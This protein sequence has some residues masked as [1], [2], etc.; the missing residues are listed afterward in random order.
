M[1][2]LT[3]ALSTSVLAASGAPQLVCY[4]VSDPDRNIHLIY[5]AHELNLNLYKRKSS[6][7]LLPDCSTESAP[8]LD[9]CRVCV[10]EEQVTA[11]CYLSDPSADL[12]FEAK[13]E[14][15]S[16]TRI[17][18]VSSTVMA[19]TAP[20]TRSAA[21][22][23]P[24]GGS[25]ASIVYG[26]CGGLCFLVLAALAYCQRKKIKSWMPC[27]SFYR[28]VLKDEEKETEMTTKP[29]AANAKGPTIPASHE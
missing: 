5:Y 1:V 26:V 4:A 23:S 15:L 13:S 11:E 17:E 9:T 27:C 16:K 6:E 22:T 2:L 18:C 14:P 24:D 25:T 10:R 19:P 7:L 8:G 3:L 20:P 28:S 12:N 21:P 29:S